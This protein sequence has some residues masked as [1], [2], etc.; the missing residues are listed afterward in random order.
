M[1]TRPTIKYLLQDAA[2]TLARVATLPGQAWVEAELLVAHA[3]KKDRAFVL[4]HGDDPLPVTQT[5]TLRTLV[6]RRLAQEPM[7]YVL[8]RAEFLGRSFFV[9]KRV[10]IPRPETELLVRATLDL[11]SQ[12][13]APRTV[14]E[15]GTGSGAIAITLKARFPKDAVLATDLSPTALTVAKKNA[16]ALLPNTPPAFLR[17]HLLDATVLRALNKYP[18]PLVVVAN[19]PYLPFS[20]K[21]RLEKSVTQFEPSTALFAKKEGLALNEALL[22]QCATLRATGHPLHAIALEYDP[23]QTSTLRAYAQRLFPDAAI[24]ILQDDCGRDRV[25]TLTIPQ[26]SY[27]RS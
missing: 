11:A 5:R 9:D 17:A 3:C 7:A 6:A 4:A 10:L 20:D 2:K 24:K 26:T 27:R 1:N 25:L 16:R 8:Q 14:L 15:I 22:A 12:K 18:H 19:L 13:R 23:P 21:K